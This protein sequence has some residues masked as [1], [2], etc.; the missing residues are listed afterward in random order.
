MGFFRDIGL[1]GR[2]FR[3]TI[4]LRRVYCRKFRVY[5]GL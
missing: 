3:K 1:F 4:H 2:F 5:G